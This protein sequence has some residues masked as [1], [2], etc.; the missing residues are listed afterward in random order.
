MELAL[1]EG[2]EA[3]VAGDNTAAEVQKQTVGKSRS[4]RTAEARTTDRHDYSK[5]RSFRRDVI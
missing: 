1:G 2:G 5:E 3:V 4:E